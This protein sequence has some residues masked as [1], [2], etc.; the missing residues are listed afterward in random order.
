MITADLKSHSNYSSPPAFS[1]GRAASLA[2]V[3]AILAL[4][5]TYGCSNGD[6]ES[7]VLE[8]PT[9]SPTPAPRDP[10]A[11]EE[12]LHQFVEAVQAGNV[13]DAWALYA[14]DVPGN[15]PSHWQNEGCDY[16]VFTFEFPKIQH[17]FERAAPFITEQW[18]GSALGVTV[19]ELSVRGAD[20][21]QYLAT[22]ARSEPH[23]PYQVRFLN[24][25]RPALIPGVPDP[26]P[27]PEDPMGYCGIWTGAR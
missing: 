15:T 17:L 2:V 6:D 27:S 7:S 16:G 22:L 5:A 23:G 20:G 21:L 19:V 14:G 25:G 11:A 18:Y 24:N 9:P 10:A 3:L 12:T 1:S 4:L 26:L 13:E 8:S